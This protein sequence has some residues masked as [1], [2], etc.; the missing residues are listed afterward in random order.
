MGAR[1]A[2]EAQALAPAAWGPAV[3]LCL[4]PGAGHAGAARGRPLQ[5]L[6][7]E[8]GRRGLR[9]G[10]CSDSGSGFGAGG[11]GGGGGAEGAAAATEAAAGAAAGAVAGITTALA[12]SGTL[13]GSDGARF[14]T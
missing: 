10:S 4:G 8:L 1:L 12:F 13:A 7:E 6:E 14:S 11:G 9:S 5:H 3:A 2:L